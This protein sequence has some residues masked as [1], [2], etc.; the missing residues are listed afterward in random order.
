MYCGFIT[1]ES[2]FI[3][4]NHSILIQFLW[5]GFC[6]YHTILLNQKSNITNYIGRANEK[7]FNLYRSYCCSILCL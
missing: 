1:Y 2:Q 7:F 3:V 5:F 6:K 4:Q